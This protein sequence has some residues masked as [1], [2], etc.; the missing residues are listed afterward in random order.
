MEPTESNESVE[1][2]NMIANLKDQSPTD[3]IEYNEFDFLS[4]S[5]ESKNIENM[6]LANIMSQQNQFNNNNHINNNSSQDRVE[7]L[8]MLPLTPKTEKELFGFLRSQ[9][10][11]FDFGINSN[12]INQEPPTAAIITG[13]D[14]NNIF[15]Q[16]FLNDAPN[17]LSNLEHQ[18]QV[19][20]SSTA[21]A[22]ADLDHVY[23]NKRRLSSFDDSSYLTD[24]SSL[25][26]A[27]SNSSQLDS[28]AKK[29]RVKGIYRQSDITNEEER[30]NYI[31]RR[32]KN[33]ISSKNSRA[34]KKNYYSSLDDKC[35]E[36]SEENN[37][38]EYKIQMLEKANKFMK[39]HLIQRVSGK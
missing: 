15:G 26:Y 22:S 9:S 13:N 6:D 20:S 12:S 30:K 28:F 33:N 7:E 32:K 19:N 2:E 16:V 23:S 35:I 17:E 27:P 29:R 3:S 14:L 25:A 21:T 11:N 8:E 10:I 4:Q 5:L 37:L 1:P 18:L 38:L 24:D 31:E 39:E 36:L 34:N